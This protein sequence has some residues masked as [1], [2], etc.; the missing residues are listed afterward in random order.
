[1]KYLISTILLLGT[2]IAYSESMIWATIFAEIQ[3]M[4]TFII[5]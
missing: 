1:M 5:F 3:L 2:G 4:K